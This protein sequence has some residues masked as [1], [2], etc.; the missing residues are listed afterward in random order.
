M[1]KIYLFVAIVLLSFNVSNAQKNTSSVSVEIG[2][3]RIDQWGSKADQIF[4]LDNGN[5]MMLKSSKS[6][7]VLNFRLYDSEMKFIDSYN[8]NKSDFYK[9]WNPEERVRIL[10]FREVKDK[11]QLFYS[12]ERS[13]ELEVMTCHFDAANRT[14]SKTSRKIFSRKLSEESERIQFSFARSANNTRYLITL[15]EENLSGEETAYHYL[16]TDDLRVIKKVNFSNLKRT[17]GYVYTGS[18]VNNDG[19]IVSTAFEIE[20]GDEPE[21]EESVFLPLYLQF[22]R[23]NETKPIIKEIDIENK[24]LTDIVLGFNTE[25]TEI[26]VG[27]IYKE[28]LKLSSAGVFLAKYDAN[29]PDAIV[30]ELTG[31]DEDL[32][33]SMFKSYV[34]GDSEDP[35]LIDQQLVKIIQDKEQGFYFVLDSG[36]AY[37]SQGITVISLDD[38][39]VK[40]WD[41]HILRSLNGNSDFKFNAYLKLISFIKD[42]EFH[43]F[44]NQSLN[45]NKLK[46]S[47]NRMLAL[48]GKSDLVHYTFNEEGEYAFEKILTFKDA[49]NALLNSYAYKDGSIYFKAGGQMRK[50]R[51]VR[52]KIY[53]D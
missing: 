1:K 52:A 39:G 12:I 46:P 20:L 35:G 37:T 17:N 13:N 6:S 47:A 16:M 28:P 24:Q 29:Y 11:F 38:S 10:F 31:F 48:N 27:G 26:V 45:F 15:Y 51:L 33:Q 25:G 50:S 14:F 30:E 8:L 3:Q 36:S 34:E 7:A 5:I 9:D 44:I 53:E 19:T 40:R 49:G 21:S 42:D 2:P 32:K 4:H 41:K 22:L 18:A 23:I 43:L